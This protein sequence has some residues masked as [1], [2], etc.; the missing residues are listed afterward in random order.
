MIEGEGHKTEVSEFDQERIEQKKIGSIRKPN[1]GVR[2]F[3][4]NLETGDV[5][6]VEL[7]GEIS[8]DSINKKEISNRKAHIKKGFVYDWAINK[9]NAKR[10]IENKYKF[11][12][13][14]KRHERSKIN[15]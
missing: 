1:N 15:D 5:G 3:E 8:Y 14:L 4:Y 10:K 12:I 11:L 13:E 6:E 2:L 9:K 7:T